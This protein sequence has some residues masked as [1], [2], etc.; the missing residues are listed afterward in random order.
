MFNCT[1]TRGPRKP[2]FQ[3]EQLEEYLIEKVGVLM[4]HN[5]ILSLCWERTEEIRTV[6]PLPS[7]RPVS[8]WR[9]FLQSEASVCSPA[10]NTQPWLDVTGWWCWQ[11]WWGPVCGACQITT[12]LHYQSLPQ[13]DTVTP[14]DQIPGHR[15]RHWHQHTTT[16]DYGA[17]GPVLWTRRETG[18]G[19]NTNCVNWR[20]L[21]G[22]P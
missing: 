3:A 12:V 11:W 16:E 19:V 9:Y 10:P 1:Q 4:T 14:S 18:T 15:H 22:D 5:W 7:A 13:S 21:S 20:E 2:H 6:L 17:E 8:S